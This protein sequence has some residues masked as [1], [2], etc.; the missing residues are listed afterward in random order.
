MNYVESVALNHVIGS[1]ITEAAC[2]TII[3]QRLCLSGMRWKDKGAGV[4]LSL[5]TLI[6][7]SGRWD[8]FW[9]K[10]GD[11]HLNCVNSC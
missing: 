2:K 1:N 10:V 11:C 5:K 9:K 6:Y 8:Q 4:I 7:S 3:K